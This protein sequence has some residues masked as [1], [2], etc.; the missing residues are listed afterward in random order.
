MVLVPLRRALFEAVPKFT[1]AVPS[2]AMVYVTPGTCWDWGWP[3][4]RF[5]ACPL[6]IMGGLELPMP[7]SAPAPLELKLKN[8]FRALASEA[9]GN[10]RVAAQYEPFSVPRDAAPEGAG[11]AMNRSKVLAFDSVFD[12][13]TA[14]GP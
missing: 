14:S 5:A 2:V 1:V 8:V 6:T 12:P 3:L 7:A 13:M 11:I 4:E 10:S 9:P